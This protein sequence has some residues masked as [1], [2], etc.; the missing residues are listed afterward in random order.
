MSGLIKSAIFSLFLALFAVSSAAP[1]SAQSVP[2]V[3][4]PVTFQ[5][6][7][8]FPRPN[9]SVTI[10]A[11]SYTTDLD[12]AAFTWYVGNKVFKKGTGITEV[13]VPVGT[14]AVSVSVDVTT[15]DIGTISKSATIR[16]GSVDLL[17]QSDGYTPPF[18]KGKA[19]ESYGAAFK[20]V[21]VAELFGPN[22]KKTDPKTLV[23]TW[24]KNGTTDAA[25]SGYGKDS[26]T[27][28]QSSYVRGGDDISV[29]A[30]TVSRDAGATRTIT[31]SPTVPEVVFYENS[32]LYGMVYEKALTGSIALTGEEITLK[33]VPFNVSALN[34]LSGLS[35]DWTLN[36]DALAD[37]KDEDQITLRTT[38]T[39]GGQ[40]NVGVSIQN[41]TKLLQGGQADISIFQ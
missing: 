3:S 31:I 30:S 1:V 9:T 12:R 34:P 35:L 16:P 23:Y 7:P 8:E 32:P 39:A 25:Q 19:L 40:S 22:G 29:E 6:S 24:K 20:V 37:F 21:A 11:Q 41:K 38:G 2:G 18:Y 28:T 26:Y 10:S 33:A 15:T 14:A 27:G 4:E 5:I 13:T 36:G 17:W